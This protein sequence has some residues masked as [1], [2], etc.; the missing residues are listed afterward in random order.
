MQR[1]VE[2]IGKINA[3][4]TEYERNKTKEK[5]IRF[6]WVLCF[7]LFVPLIIIY[8][9]FYRQKNLFLVSPL[10][11]MASKKN[12]N[13]SLLNT[14]IF[15][16]FLLVLSL[17]FLNLKVL[18]CFELCNRAELFI[19]SLSVSSRPQGFIL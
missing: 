13:K 16:V 1:A 14:F 9:P 5:V 15:S 6:F 18:Y 7:K 10:V 17:K 4:M 11:A 12:K 19:V 2:Q 3:I 8:L